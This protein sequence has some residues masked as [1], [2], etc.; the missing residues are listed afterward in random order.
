MATPIKDMM[1][2]VAAK[3]GIGS[4][5]KDWKEDWIEDA[6]VDWVT[7]WKGYTPANPTPP[8]DLA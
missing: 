2:D 5:K 3:N 6:R 8:A 7:D 1:D 4:T